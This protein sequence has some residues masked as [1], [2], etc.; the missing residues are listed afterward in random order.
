MRIM[1][2]RSFK[3]R[4]QILVDNAP[5][6]V[7]IALDPRFAKY[8]FRPVFMLPGAALELI[9]G[10]E[11]KNLAAQFMTAPTPI[12]RMFLEEILLFI[13]AAT[14]AH[15]NE[16]YHALK[17]RIKN[18]AY[19]DACSIGKEAFSPEETQPTYEATPSDRLR[20]EEHC[21]HK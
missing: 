21:C 16:I 18:I 19:E 2:Y 5:K 11:G 14:P 15:V 10:E 12:A 3:G 13:K 7:Q 6:I 4:E 9:K 17:P 20:V 1:L 8:T